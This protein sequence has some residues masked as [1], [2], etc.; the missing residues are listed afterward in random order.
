MPYKP[1]LCFVPDMVR[2]ERSMTLSTL[3]QRLRPMGDL[4]NVPCSKSHQLQGGRLGDIVNS[5]VGVGNMRV[6]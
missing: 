3:D 6:R 1:P 2:L 5:I 4:A